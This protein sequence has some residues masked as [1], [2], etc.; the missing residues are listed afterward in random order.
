MLTVSHKFF[1]RFKTKESETDPA[2]CIVLHFQ[3]K[4]LIFF[5]TSYIF[6]SRILVCNGAQTY[7]D[8]YW[9]ASSAWTPSSEQPPS[10]AQAFSQPPPPP[11]STLA[12][13]SWTC[14]L[15]GA[16]SLSPLAATLLMLTPRMELKTW[17]RRYS[18]LSVANPRRQEQVGPAWTRSRYE[19]LFE[20]TCRYELEVVLLSPL[21][22]RWK[23]EFPDLLTFHSLI[24][25]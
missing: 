6:F 22:R 5:I 3:E 11:P 17:R 13:R 4:K 14:C 10:E 19:W 21:A 2:Y 20:Y 18:I 8:F 7:W 23:D 15:W 9:A 1:F 12:T 16:R 24:S 25:S